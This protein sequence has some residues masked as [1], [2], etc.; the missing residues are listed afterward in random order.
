MPD[1]SASTPP[2]PAPVPDRG[3]DPVGVVLV[4][5]SA[6]GFGLMALFKSWAAA[7]GT[8]T[9][10]MLAL[11]FGIAAAVLWSIAGW[12]ATRYGERPPPARA[13]LAPLVMGA[14]LYYGEAAC[15][16]GAIDAGAPSGLVALLL[17]TFPGLVAV[18][19]WALFREALTPAKL[20]ALGL[21]LVGAALTVGRVDAAPPMG[22]ILGA[23]SSVIYAAYILAGTGLARARARGTAGGVGPLHAAA[24]VTTGAAVS[25]G[26]EA[27][28]RGS[29]LP[30]SGWGWLGVASI[31]LVST[32]FSITALLAGIAR[33]GAVRAASLSIVEPLVT[34]LVGWLALG[35][36]MTPLRAAGG[37]LILGGTVVAARAR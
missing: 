28:L 22:L 37:A 33:V 15:Y 19:A 11:R 29:A 2:R 10:A 3:I 21:A 25:F 36:A 27:A 6:C 30:A 31:A 17:Y 1:D 16:F 4:L 12:R 7:G 34:V 23:M 18:G 9:S 20:G 5:L 26:L 8:G 24:L 13:M 14:V 32:V 35:E